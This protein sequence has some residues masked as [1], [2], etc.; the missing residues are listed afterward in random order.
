MS[1][2]TI[3]YATMD[4]YEDLCRLFA[5]VDKYHVELVPE[6]FQEFPGPARSRERLSHFVDNEN[7]EAIVAQD[8]G[9]IV[10]LLTLEKSDYPSYPMFKRREH[11]MIHTLVVDEARRRQGIGGLLLDAAAGWARDRGVRFIQTNVWRANADAREFYSK[12]GFQ[13]LTER[14]EMEI[15]GNITSG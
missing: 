8:E 14:I 9:K 10:G 6:I 15:E 1:E 11:A 4:D 2:V 3:R 7:A 5:Q 13:T 12:H